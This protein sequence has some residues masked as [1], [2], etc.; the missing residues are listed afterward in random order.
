MQSLIDNKQQLLEFITDFLKPKDVEKKKFGE[1]FTPM[2]LVNEMLDKLP[3]KVWKDKNL[4]WL[5]PASGMGNFPVAIYLR[6]IESLKDL[7]P[8]DNERKRHIL[9]N[10]LYMCELNK[11]NVFICEMIFDYKLNIYQGDSL[12]VDYNKKFGVDKFDIIVGNPPYQKENKKTDSARGGTNNNLYL[13]FVNMSLSLLNDN[14]YLLFIHPLN[15]RKIGSKIFTDFINRNIHYLKLNYGGEYFENVSVK[16]DY[17][18]LKNSNNKKYKSII[19]C[20]Y[21]K[22]NYKSNIILSNKL[23]FIPN[24]FNKYINSILEKIH[25]YG[26]EYKCII[27]SDCHKARSHV[28]KGKDKT[29]KFPLFNTSG[30]PYEFFSSKE[31]KDHYLKKVILSNSGKL[32]PFYDDGKLGTTQ[33]S[34]YILVDSKEEGDI[35]VN[36]IISKLFM[37]LIKICQWGNFRNEASLFTYLK[38]PDFIIVNESIINDKFIYNYYNLNENEIKFLKE[39]YL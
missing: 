24:L 13:D 6:L 11:K 14:G 8:D 17:Y 25:L 31:H 29:Y 28:K 3:I 37:F 39:I 5:D 38:Y 9:E 1:V 23:K 34:M 4:K 7:I 20:I 18:V 2:S 32:S 27:S 15:W 35:I 12:K 22:K 10:M 19:E 16:T 36:A 30:H 33:D 26:K 21:N